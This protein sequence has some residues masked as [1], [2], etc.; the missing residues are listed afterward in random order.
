[1]T[2]QIVSPRV[3]SEGLKIKEAATAILGKFGLDLLSWIAHFTATCEQLA[4]LSRDIRQLRKTNE[5]YLVK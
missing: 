1:M 5:K 3:V 4:L 2:S